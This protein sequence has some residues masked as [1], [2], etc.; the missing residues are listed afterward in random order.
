MD[1][2][3]N[4]AHSSLY[5]VKSMSEVQIDDFKNTAQQLYIRT[6]SGGDRV[7]KTCTSPR[8]IRSHFREGN[9]A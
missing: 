9:W 4:I 7:H 5:P 6:Y 2:F 8:Q 3:R 1:W